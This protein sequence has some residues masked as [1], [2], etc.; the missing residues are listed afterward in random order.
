MRQGVEHRA[1]EISHHG[2][3]NGDSTLQAFCAPG[4]EQP[5]RGGHPRRL[6]PPGAVAHTAHRYQD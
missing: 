1:S 4:A 3:I 6:Q 5:E 2:S